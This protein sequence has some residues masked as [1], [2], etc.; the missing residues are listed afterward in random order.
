[1]KQVP[2]PGG[3]LFMGPGIDGLSVIPLGCMLES[4]NPPD[5]PAMTICPSVKRDLRMWI[6]FE[7]AA[8]D[9]TYPWGTHGDTVTQYK[10]P[11]IR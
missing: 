10:A 4:D 7:A 6:P 3:L 2:F 1:M 9:S 5:C 11:E 8:S